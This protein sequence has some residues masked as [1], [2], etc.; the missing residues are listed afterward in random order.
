M[1]VTIKVLRTKNLK[2]LE[3]GLFIDNSRLRVVKYIPKLFRSRLSYNF[4]AWILLKKLPMF[5]FLKFPLLTVSLLFYAIFHKEKCLW[6]STWSERKIWKFWKW[7]ISSKIYDWGLL[8]MSLNSFGLDYHIISMHGYFWKKYQSPIFWNF[9]FW[10]FL[11]CFR[12][13]FKWAFFKQKLN[14]GIF[15][16]SIHASK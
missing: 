11:Y 2:S 8:N 12:L 5:N 13:F 3:M 6:P 4:D 7:V 9:H 15:F 10:P 16:R 14:F 1:P